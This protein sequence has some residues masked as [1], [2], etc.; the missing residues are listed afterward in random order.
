MG[1]VQ[2]S[3]RVPEAVWRTPRAEHK[4]PSG[5]GHCTP[6]DAIVIFKGHS[7]S[8]YSTTTR[9]A[10]DLLSDEQIEYQIR[11]RLSFARFLGLGVEGGVPNLRRHHLLRLYREQLTRAGPWRSRSCSRPLTAI[12]PARATRPLVDRSSMPRSSPFRSSATPAGRGALAVIEE[13][14]WGLMSPGEWVL[15]PAKGA[16]KDVDAR[17]TKKHGQNGWRRRRAAGSD[18]A[19]ATRTT[20]ASTG[21]TSWCVVTP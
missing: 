9:E 14:R 21:G 1:T 18:E 6:W 20:S 11:D 5:P 15:H 2:T 17:W 4:S 13:L 16:Q 19:M 10:D 3:A 8:V 7:C 12:S